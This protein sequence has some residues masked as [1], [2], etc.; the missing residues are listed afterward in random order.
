MGKKLHFK[1]E[2]PSG[3]SRLYVTVSNSKLTAACS[4][5]QASNASSNE[6][7]S[8]AMIKVFRIHRNLG[9]DKERLKGDKK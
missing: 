6:P 8:L 2:E 5:I 4:N 3:D 9:K 7:L 1:L